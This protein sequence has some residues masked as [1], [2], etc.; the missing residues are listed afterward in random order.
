MEKQP[1]KQSK[2]GYQLLQFIFF[3]L[4][5]VKTHV[6]K[7]TINGVT[8]TFSNAE[9]SVPY[10]KID[11]I[12]LTTFVTLLK[13]SSF[14]RI[15]LGRISDELKALERS[16]DGR[17]IQ[18]SYKAIKRIFD[19]N[20]VYDKIEPVKVLKME[21][22]KTYGLR[23]GA[24][25]QILWGKGRAENELQPYLP[26]MNYIEFTNEFYTLVK[27]NSAPHIRKHIL[28][29][30]SARTLDIYHWLVLRLYELPDDILIKWAW[31]YK[32]F[33]NASNMSQM[34]QKA[35][36]TL[37]EKIK[38]SLY[39][40]RTKYYKEANVSATREGIILKPSP[41]LIEPD[42][43]KAGYSLGYKEIL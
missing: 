21:K 3:P 26:G 8:C 7:R 35:Q 4:P 30:D 41:P 6:F 40:I 10:T 33:G 20:I 32:Q 23:V 39:E 29:I 17:Y 27:F 18:S 31:L 28:E 9:N 24:I 19:L 43:P 1:K 42:N 37:K 15:E 38:K 22:E 16:R 36:R 12:W 2:L 25:K 5:Y 13:T 34:S 11:R 14:P